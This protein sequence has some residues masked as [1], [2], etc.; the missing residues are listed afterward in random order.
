MEVTKKV[1]DDCFIYNKETGDLFWKN[2]PT[3]HFKNIRARNSW[4]TKYSGKQVGTV[5]NTNSGK[6]YILTSIFNKKYHIHR[7]IWF[8]WSGN[9]PKNEIDHING[10]ST[11]NRICNLRDV[12][13]SENNKNL[14][15]SKRNNSGHIGVREYKH[16][17][18]VEIGY[19]G[20]SKYIGKFKTMNEAVEARKMA[21]KKYWG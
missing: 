8:L 1:L 3:S 6:Q 18:I 13:R 11:D 5:H 19:K 7:I 2:R 14:R 16:G 4:N 12:T 17:F 9:W 21:E 15:I 20:K 10:V